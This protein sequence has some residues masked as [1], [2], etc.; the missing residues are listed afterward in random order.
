MRCGSKKILDFK[1]Q[2]SKDSY[3]QGLSFLGKKRRGGLNI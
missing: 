2:V 1:K 3:L